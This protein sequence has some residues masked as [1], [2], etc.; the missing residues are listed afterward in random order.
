MPTGCLRCARALGALGLLHSV[1]HG[2]QL[3][4]GEVLDGDARGK[5]GLLDAAHRRRNL[6]VEARSARS[7]SMPSLR[8]TFTRANSMSPNSSS[9]AAL[10]GSSASNSARSEATSSHTAS[11]ESHSNPTFAARLETFC[12]CM[13]AG[14]AWGTL[15]SSPSGARRPSPACVRS[16]FFTWVPDVEHLARVCRAAARAEHVRMA[17]D[18]LLV[19]LAHHVLDGERMRV[20]CD[21][22]VQHHLHEHVAELL[23]QMRG[24]TRLD[25]VDGLVGLLDHVLRDALMRL[26]P[27]PRTSVRL[28]QAPDGLGQRVKGVAGVGASRAIALRC[29]KPHRQR[30]RASPTPPQA[31]RDGTPP[32]PDVRSRRCR[33]CCCRP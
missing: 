6:A 17:A 11:T 15:S 3:L 16:S 4:G 8:A 9:R 13:R 7:A 10:P 33:S 18:E 32:P 14:N 23:A 24:V 26:L 29:A 28:A 5:R 1:P 19:E 20:R 12:A 22:G 2:V 31:P 27:V 21:L 25:A 30:G